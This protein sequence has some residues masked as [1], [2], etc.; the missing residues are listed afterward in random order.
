M[1]EILV[2]VIF[3][4]SSRDKSIACII[5]RE[6]PVIGCKS[7]VIDALLWEVGGLVALMLSRMRLALS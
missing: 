3:I 1:H 4:S 2:G 7:Y 6:Y 5:E